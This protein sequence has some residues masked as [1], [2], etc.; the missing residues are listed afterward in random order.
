MPLGAPGR[1]TR[2][3]RTLIGWK[4]CLREDAAGETKAPKGWE[5]ARPLGPGIVCGT[6]LGAPKSVLA[7][8]SKARSP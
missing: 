3:D 6:D 4:S 8:S 5:E 1:T 7:P 2:S